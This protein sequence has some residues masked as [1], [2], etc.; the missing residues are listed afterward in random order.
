MHGSS[1]SKI[2]EYFYSSHVH[3]IPPI[4]HKLCVDCMINR[5]ICHCLE[6]SLLPGSAGSNYHV[7][8]KSLH[9]NISQPSKM[10]IISRDSEALLS[11]DNFSQPSHITLIS[12]ES[13]VLLSNDTFSQP[14]QITLISRD[15]DIFFYMTSHMT[16]E[17]SD[18]ATRTWCK[19]RICNECIKLKTG[20]VFGNHPGLYSGVILQ[21][22]PYLEVFNIITNHAI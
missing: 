1:F 5:I 11:N 3:L 15:S 21:I 10:K 17:T 16:S 12:Q 22:F 14:S 7:S 19:I 18:K 2:L 9:D 20:S 6:V 13:E 8:A 4:P